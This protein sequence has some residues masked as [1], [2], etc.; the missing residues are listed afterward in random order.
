MINTLRGS[1]SIATQA[2]READGK[3]RHTTT[4][5]EM[6][7]LGRGADG[8]G[9]L[10]DTPGMRELQLADASSGIA[11][12]F[13]DIEAMTL[14]CRFTNCTHGREPECAVQAAIAQ[15]TLDAARLER[16][17]KLTDEEAVNTGTTSGPGT[18]SARRTHA[19]R[20]NK[21]R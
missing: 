15:G 1:D 13:D 12:V 18:T 8:G 9:W 16:W 17:R 4:V 19:G 3:G 6:H 2:V 10:V 20:P 7:R 14:E 21:R 11:E 5:R